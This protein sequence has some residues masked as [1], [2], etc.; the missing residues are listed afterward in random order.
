MSVIDSA[1]RVALVADEELARLLDDLDHASIQALSDAD[2]LHSITVKT[3]LLAQVQAFLDAELVEAETRGVAQ[4][5]FG[6]STATWFAGTTNAVDSRQAGRMVKQAVAIHARFPVLER[7]LRAGG[8]SSQ[9]AEAIY[10]GLQHLP[11]DLDAEAIDRADRQMADFA[12]TY[13][14]TELRRLG[15]RLI[16][17]IAPTVAEA[18]AA[19]YLQR[20]EAEARRSRSLRFH[21]DHHGSWR[22]S[23]QLPIADGAQLAELIT[24][25]AHTGDDNRINTRED[26]ALGREQRCWSA[27]CADALVEIIHA[28][29][30]TGTAPAAGGDRPR[31]NVT[32]DLAT[33]QGQLGHA[34]LGNGAPISAGEARRLACD[35]HLLPVV[36]DGPSAPVD[37]GRDH[38]LVTGALR[39][40]L[41]ARDRGC[42]YPGCER[43]PTGCEAHHIQ[44]WWSG[45]R[46]ALDNTA[47]LCRHHHQLVEP[48]PNKPPDHQWELHL[49][50]RG[51]PQVRPPAWADRNRTPRQHLRYRN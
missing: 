7:T 13:N 28:Y 39:L 16:D 5:R 31:I 51:L 8:V 11:I 27:K 42:C 37:V 30:T 47:L 36:L 4:N 19:A 32:I 6:V 45:G 25:L 3:R 2:L 49:D 40:A 20:V 22:F 29:Q 14:P 38:R 21:D 48:N 12:S 1:P 33:L 43:P 18:D 9:Q 44:P 50:R 34:T 17:V 46:T 41:T 15:N 10:T 24:A 35:A 23:G 26:D